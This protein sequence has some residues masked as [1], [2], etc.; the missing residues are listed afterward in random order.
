MGGA[1]AEPIFARCRV[2]PWAGLG[3]GNWV[4]VGGTGAVAD[5]GVAWGAGRPWALVSPAA[6][7]SGFGS[8]DRAAPWV[9]ALW[10]WVK[11]GGG[12]KRFHVGEADEVVILHL[13]DIGGL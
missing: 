7:L 3:M 11:V 9:P 10:F 2:R 13:S 8:L 12:W 6:I 4:G 5:S 1:A